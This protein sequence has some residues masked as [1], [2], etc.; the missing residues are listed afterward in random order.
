MG[1]ETT[2]EQ[3]NEPKWTYENDESNKQAGPFQKIVIS[4]FA[5]KFWKN[6]I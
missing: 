4:I 6:L 2:S 5:R 3:A 1:K